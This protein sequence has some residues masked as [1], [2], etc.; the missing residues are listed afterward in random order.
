MDADVVVVGAGPAGCH[1]AREL[2]ARGWR[3]LLADRSRFP[4]W[5]P[6]GG[7]LSQRAWDRLP[8]ELRELA[9]AEVSAADLRLGARGRVLLQASRPVGRLVHRPTFDLANLELAA[10]ADRVETLLG[11]P[12]AAVREQHDGVA[13]EGPGRALRARVVIGAD[14]AEGAV[15]RALRR[16]DPRPRAVAVETEVELPPGERPLLF[17]FGAP[18][19]GYG[20][21]FAKGP[22]SSLGVCV[23]AG[24]GRGLRLQ[25]ER[26][27]AAL[28]LA[29]VAGPV[30]GAPVPLGGARVRAVSGRVILVGDAADTVDPLT[31]EGIGGALESAEL[32]AEA[33]DRF[34][35]R[36]EPLSRY[37]RSL[38]RRVHRPLAIA[39]RVAPAL[40]RRS[41]RTFRLLLA[42]RDVGARFVA[43]LRG[44]ASYARLLATAA[45]RVPGRALAGR[46]AI[47]NVRHVVP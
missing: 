35:A 5:K 9:V 30:R 22:L 26:F 24:T 34:L 1:A 31:G 19:G 33:V 11:W 16:G 4:R 41:E 38:W 39:H 18:P 28:G 20:W 47:R 42:D 43:L 12:V 10:A 37:Q 2:A 8:Q 17:D 7:A 14:G 40:Y 36:G 46:E 29:P 21:L 25:L 45:R 3:V 13:V 44:E 23:V 15:G 32:A 27:A 6:C